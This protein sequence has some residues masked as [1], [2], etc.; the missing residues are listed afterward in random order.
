[1]ITLN[2]ILVPTDFSE[3]AE[4]AYSVAQ[5]IASTFGG[6]IDFIHVIPTLK[7]VNESIK[8]LGVPLDMNKDVYPKVIDEAEQKLKKAMGSYLR[9]ENKGDYFIKIER[10]P[11]ETITTFANKNG[12]DLIVMGAKG[13]DESVS[14]RGT[15]TERVIRRSKVPV[16]SVNKRFD[17][18]KI[19]NIVVPTDTSE[20]SI[21]A[22]PLSA[23]LADT[24]GSRITLY[25]VI[26]LYGSVSEEIPRTAGKGE[27]VSVYE[28][29]IERINNFLD[30]R[31]IDNIH[32]QRT[33]VTFEDE[34][35]ITDGEN[36]RSIPLFTKIDK[37]VSAH[38]EI[39]NYAGEEADLVVMATHGHSGL[40]HLILGS[41]AEKVAQYVKKPVITVR[42][43]EEDFAG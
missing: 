38:Y 28:A 16:F 20:L 39:E 21:S 10:K 36:S 26:E 41:T 17:S 7:Y 19:E 34:V 30:K 11:S 40:A 37:G 4:G 15:V 33:G 32:I 9:D 27:M 18:N 22:F 6:K 8:R 13:K 2:K 31:K 14:M 3:G 29:L 43:S 24:F 42:P 1:M 12:Y 35:V 5:N 25:H 23:A